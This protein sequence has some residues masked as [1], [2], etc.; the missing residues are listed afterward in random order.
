MF[1]DSNDAA[2]LAVMEREQRNER[3]AVA[4][5]LLAAGRL[6]QLRMA[7]VDGVDRTQWCID[8]WEAVAAEVGSAVGIQPGTASAQMSYGT[9]LLEGLP[10]LAARFVAGEVDCRVV[11]VA[12][13]RTGLITDP[14]LL[15]A[16]DERLAARVSVCNRMSR[17]KLAEYVDWLVL[18]L[19]P[20]AVR[21]ARQ[22]QTDRHVEIGSSRDGLAENWGS[23]RAPDAALVDRRLDQLVATVC[24]EDP[25]TARQRRADALA[26]L[27]SGAPRLVCECGSPD[28]P[29]GN[30]AAP[31]GQV[32]IHV[33]AEA[34]TLAG[35]ADA[36]GYLPGHGA[37]Q[38][39]ALR[40]LASAGGRV[41]P[42]R[43]PADLGAEPGY[44]PSTA[45]ADF[46]RCRDLCCRFPGCDRPAEV[47]DIDHT[48]PW[49][50]GGLTHPSNLALLSRAHHLIKTFWDGEKGWAERQFA[51]GAI[52]W[53][54]PSG[55][56]Y[57]T[58]PR[59]ALFFP[60]LAVRTGPARITPQE[61]KSGRARGLMMPA[62]RCSRVAERSARIQW[63]RAGLAI[64]RLSRHS[65]SDPRTPGDP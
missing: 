5:R 49:E 3:T 30:V 34:A 41:R 1:D 22:A 38:A 57:T 9:A 32:V 26:A 18:E 31:S 20:A 61:T 63:E 47:C 65:S 29:V 11:A 62:R 44:R 4:R 10:K 42:L 21:V 16:V 7:A 8:N 6:C 28:C 23:V 58:T 27:A 52:L 39:D 51:D 17:G 50:R 13:F 24:R 37:V 2:L 25:R 19:D 14:D 33:R 55:R 56:T 12:V 36:P 53:T 46:I 15:A 45:L 60:Q 48:V 43:A 64:R 40:A 59:G 54:S 35:A